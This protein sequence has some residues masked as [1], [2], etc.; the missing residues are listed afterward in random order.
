MTG[1]NIEFQC[2]SVEIRCRARAEFRVYVY[3]SVG[4]KQRRVN[5]L[6]VI[7]AMLHVISYFL[8]ARTYLKG[9]LLGLS[10]LAT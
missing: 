9:F 6:R 7:H 3:P 5:F 2:V 1:L 4:Q 8:V 10:A